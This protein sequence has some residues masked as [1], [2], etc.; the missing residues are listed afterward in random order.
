MQG[1][2]FLLRLI[3]L[4]IEVLVLLMHA[5]GV[6][7]MSTKHLFVVLWSGGNMGLC[8][9]RVCLCGHRGIVSSRCAVMSLSCGHEMLSSWSSRCRMLN[10][11]RS[12]VCLY[13]H[14]LSVVR[15]M[16]MKHDLFV[17]INVVW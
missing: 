17:V 16:I 11:H 12:W 7:T 1:Q 15:W 4:S 8:R 13:T 3:E 9:F 2:V 6:S 14:Y 5:I 10:M